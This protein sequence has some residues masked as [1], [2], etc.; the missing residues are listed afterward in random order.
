MRHRYYHTLSDGQKTVVR[1][2]LDRLTEGQP[3]KNKEALNR[4][5]N[6][7]T[8]KNEV[9]VSSGYCLRCGLPGHVSASC[10]RS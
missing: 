10:R 6:L 2:A 1:T 9:E 5:S 7:F 3:G 8:N 4:L